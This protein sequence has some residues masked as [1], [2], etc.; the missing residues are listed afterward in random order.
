MWLLT[1]VDPNTVKHKGIERLRAS[2]NSIVVWKVHRRVRAALI[3]AANARRG[4]A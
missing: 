1:C 3:I 4:A 2:R